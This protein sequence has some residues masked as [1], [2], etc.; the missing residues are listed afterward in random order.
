METNVDT[1]RTFLVELQ[2]TVNLGMFF[3]WLIVVIHNV[4]TYISYML[5]RSKTTSTIFLS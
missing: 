5:K 1:Q 3:Y 4:P 2:E